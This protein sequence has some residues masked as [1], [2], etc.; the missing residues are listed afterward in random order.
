M[1]Q[2]YVDEGLEIPK[3]KRRIVKQWIKQI[4]SDHGK[5]TGNIVY[6]FCNDETILKY[7]N[8]FLSHDYY[9]DIITFDYCDEKMVNG[10]MLISVDTVRSNSE[11]LGIHYLEEL[12]RVMIH[13]V[14][15]LIGFGDKSEKEEKKMRQK[16]NESL[17]LLHK[18]ILLK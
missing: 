5:K 1:I 16:E 17:E 3:I 4:I 6:R 11:M 10:D 13:G 14:L 18:M 2:I 8:E 7:N 9:T 12:Y 15:H